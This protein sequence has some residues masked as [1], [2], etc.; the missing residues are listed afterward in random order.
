MKHSTASAVRRSPGTCRLAD[1]TNR[2]SWRRRSTDWP[3]PVFQLFAANEESRAA[4]IPALQTMEV[5]S[6]AIEFSSLSAL[7]FSS[8]Q[9]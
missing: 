5:L 8:L 2:S 9:G 7:E 1:S 4:R 3:S 6:T